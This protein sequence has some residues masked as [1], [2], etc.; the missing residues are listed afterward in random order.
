[1]YLYL[2]FKQYKIPN[3]SRLIAFIPNFLLNDYTLCRYIHVIECLPDK[4]G[5]YKMKKSSLVA[6]IGISI[7]V[8]KATAVALNDYAA[9][10]GIGI[11]TVIVMRFAVNKI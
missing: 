6:T 7:G 4:L 1:M 2:N 9:G 10:F 5:I 3:N 8:G 11:A